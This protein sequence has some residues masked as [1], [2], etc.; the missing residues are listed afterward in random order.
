MVMSAKKLA[1]DKA[2]EAEEV[3]EVTDKTEKFLEL[4]NKETAKIKRL[5]TI[6]LTDD[7]VKSEES[8]RMDEK[9]AHKAISTLCNA[10]DITLN[11]KNGT[12][13]HSF[14]AKN[15]LIVSALVKYA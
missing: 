2:F 6:A 3:T 8:Y 1:F 4:L 12:V 10:Y 11:S 9:T 5:E 13:F 7:K 15:G 14:Q